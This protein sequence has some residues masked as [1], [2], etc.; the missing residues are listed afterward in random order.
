M[1]IET[2]DSLV[3]TAVIRL[4]LAQI[5]D[6][7]YPLIDENPF[8]PGDQYTISIAA[9][10][11][12]D[13][14]VF[15][16]F[17]A[18]IRPHFEAI[19]S[20]CYLEILLADHALI[21]N[22]EDRSVAYPDSS[23]SDIAGE[24][25]SKYNINLEADETDAK[26]DSE[27][28][29]QFQRTN[30]WSFLKYLAKRNGFTV[31][32]QPDPVNGETKCH[33]KKR[34]IDSSPQPDLTILRENSNLDWIDFQ[35]SCDHPYERSA[36]D[37]DPIEKKLIRSDAS[38]IDNPMGDNLFVEESEQGVI[39]AGATAASRHIRGFLPRDVSM[40][41]EAKGHISK[42]HLVIQVAGS[43]SP[44]LYRGL[45]TAN[46]AAL[47]KGVGE[48]LSGIYYINRLI[49]TLENGN[50]SQQ[51]FGVSNALGRAGSEQ[52]GQSAEQEAAV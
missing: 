12:N 16:G 17:V 49:T 52:F 33:F 24:I 7:Q 45:L 40:N 1:V 2:G 37:I 9:P 4:S 26:P 36:L 15:V 35:I 28:I 30:D 41:T 47:I 51:F 3:G 8:A 42:D 31:Y 38:S 29:I 20:N 48:R 27:D 44:S 23:D 18:A 13:T 43:L 50:I 22:S 21:L 39:R 25:L 6:G 19:E 46:A 34:D 14:T 32:F 10:G 5:S 11:G